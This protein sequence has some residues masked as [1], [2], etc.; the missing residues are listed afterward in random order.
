MSAVQKVLQQRE[1]FAK[2][3]TAPSSSTAGVKAPIPT[4]ARA[5][6]AVAPAAAAAAGMKLPSISMP[7]FT[8][9]ISFLFY[10][11]LVVF[12]LFLILVFIHFTIRPIF[13]TSPTE[14]GAPLGNVMTNDM[15]TAWDKGAVADTKAEFKSPKSCDMTL[16]M[17][18]YSTGEY[19]S[20]VAPKVFLYR[21]D[22]AATI[23]A[24]ANVSDLLTTLS[25]TNLIIYFDNLTGNLV[26]SAVTV[27]NNKK[28]LESSA[29][30][31]NLP[32]KKP[33]R[34][35]LVLTAKFFEVYIDGKLRETVTLTGTLVESTKP[36]WSQPVRFDKVVRVGKLHYWPRP[37]TAGEIR[38]L[39]P[40]VASDFFI[41]KT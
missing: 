16:S 14:I 15:Q 38:N 7:G 18:V 17:D 4:T 41:Q 29:A 22:A 9:I 40:V 37:L 19:T 11:S 27:A 1:A 33:F 32:T 23:A 24:N 5:A 3:L 30:I 35:S 34:L 10:S 28:Q 21:A 31:P 6:T 2:G 26:V 12:F 36:F 20:V 25:T 8:S 13:Q 39:E